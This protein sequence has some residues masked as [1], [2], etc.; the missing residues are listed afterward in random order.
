MGLLTVASVMFGDFLFYVLATMRESSVPFSMKL[1]T[2]VAHSFWA[3]ESDK[4]IASILFALI[5]AGYV[6]Y[7]TRRPSFKAVFQPLGTPGE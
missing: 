7:T 5:G 1:V 3:I 2:L 4:G 6:I